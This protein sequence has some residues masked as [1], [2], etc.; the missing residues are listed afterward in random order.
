MNAKEQWR[1]A[2]VGSLLL[3]GAVANMRAG[4]YSTRFALNETPLREGGNWRDG[5]A[6]G[7]DWTDVGVTNHVAVC[8][9]DGSAAYNDSTAILTGTWGSN[10]I[11]TATLFA[12][13]QYGDVYPEVEIRLRSAISAHSATGYEVA[14]SLRNDNITYIGVVRWNGPYGNWTPIA[15][16]SGSQYVA[17]NGSTLKAQ[18]IGSTITIYL[19]GKQVIQTND[20]TFT[21]GN[22]GIGFYNSPGNL[23]KNGT[24]GYSAVT[25][26]DGSPSLSIEWDGDD[27]HLTGNGLP[28]G[29]YTFEY[30]Q[31]LG[32]PDWKP[33][34]TVFS[35]D[36]GLFEFIDPFP[37]RGGDRFYRT[38]SQ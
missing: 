15:N 3:C 32:K 4:T 6:D 33:L 19:N 8:T 23:A 17:T 28:N 5:K 38:V 12:P 13:I 21:N 22:P 30:A 7:L 34:A 35:D 2:V 10:Q 31:D 29:A 20:T 18:I 27:T 16:V 25:A 24:F 26:T 37:V 14:Y 1:T 36:S 11:V 9:M